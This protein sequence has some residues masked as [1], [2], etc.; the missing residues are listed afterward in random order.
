MKHDSGALLTE[1]LYDDDVEVRL[2]APLWQ[3]HRAD[4]HD[5]LLA[6][7]RELGVEITMGA[8]V[9]RFEWNAPSAL[10]EDGTVI[11]ADVV[12]VTDGKLT[13]MLQSIISG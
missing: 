5:V 6:K 12:L 9:E 13:Y 11:A 7:A 1:S 2:G 10:L 3:I 4:L 8:K